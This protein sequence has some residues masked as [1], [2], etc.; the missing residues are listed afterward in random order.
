MPITGDFK[1]LAAM[2]K[3]VENL[4]NVPEKIAPVCA[5][6]FHVFTDQGFATSTDPYGRGWKPLLPQTIAAHG[7][8]RILLDSGKMNR[9]AGFLPYGP[10]VKIDIGAFYARFHIS[11]GRGFLPMNGKLP[12][13]WA[14]AID[15]EST[16][17][18]SAIARGT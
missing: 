8:H 3:R 16:K 15:K 7:A 17:A 13:K 4:V 9:S 11:T 1:K 12:A 6:H 18:F 2:K 5:Q 10:K 14:T